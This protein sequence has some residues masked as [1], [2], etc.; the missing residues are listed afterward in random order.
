MLNRRIT[1]RTKIVS[2]FLLI[3]LF[4]A[5]NSIVSF[6]YLK[7]SEAITEQ[8]SSVNRPS[9]LLLSEYKLLVHD[10][11]SYTNTWTKVDIE[12][13]PDKKALIKIHEKDYKMLSDSVLN[14]SKL[15]SDANDQEKIKIAVASMDTVIL[16]QKSIMS[17]L[18]SFDAYL[19]FMS[20]MEAEGL[21]E[22]VN[23]L[24]DEVS[25]LV[26]EV[27]ENQK[28][29][30][31]TEEAK[32]LDSF[33]KLRFSNT[34]LAGFVVILGV[35]VALLLSNAIIKPVNQLKKVI[36]QLGKGKLPKVKGIK[37]NDEIGDMAL[38]VSNL[39][40]GLSKLSEFAEKIGEGELNVSFKPLS[41]EDVLGNSLLS[42]RSNLQKAEDDKK[43]HQKGEEKR[44]W[45]TQGL[46]QFASILR[47]ENDIEELA[48]DL[49]SNLVRY[50]GANQGGIYLVNDG[51]KGEDASLDLTSCYA[52][53]RQKFIERKIA[54]GEGLLGQC[55]LEKQKLYMTEVPDG[56]LTIHSGLGEATANCLLIVPLVVNN[57][58]FGMLEVASFKEFEDYEVDFI[59]RLGE[60]IAA[61]LSTVKVNERT[62]N[63]LVESQYMEEQLRAQ[64]EE[65]RQNMEEL[66]ATQ[67]EM[68]RKD[69]MQQERI[70]E[71]ERKVAE[72]KSA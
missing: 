28:I 18:S 8:I 41:K 17:Q 56:Y 64:E 35:L 4:F 44:N 36:K 22:I 40:N 27:I 50:V 47:T 53:D 31:N 38:A 67:E 19:D 45:A 34:F 39:S 15:W 62:T 32:M 51:E 13:H 1:I 59:E 14:L 52:Y 54:K 12:D 16:N 48:N 43:A 57:E 55:W 7:K 72:Q 20:K 33:G 46:A 3:I 25:V 66:Q 63:L 23:P 58:V 69:R 2:G 60:A 37:S 42:M 70:E 10:A 61:T 30:S 68:K 29:I 26:S 65:M 24:S 9:I 49:I 21:L 11:K 6:F 5:G 71:L